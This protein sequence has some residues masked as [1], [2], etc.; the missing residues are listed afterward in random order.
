MVCCYCGKAWNYD[1]VSPKD[2][3]MEEAVDHEKICPENPYTMRIRE[4]EAT[5]RIIANQHLR[6]EMDDHTGEHADWEG[7]YEG[8]VKLA[9]KAISSENR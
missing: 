4:V 7:G 5:L 6:A 3:L 8:I 2:E 9:R 1:G